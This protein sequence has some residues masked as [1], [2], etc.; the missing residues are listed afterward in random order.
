MTNDSKPDEVDGDGKHTRPFAQFIR[1]V[2][3]G[4]T[5]DEATEKLAE[6]VEAVRETGKAGKMS[7]TLT[8]KPMKGNVDVLLVEDSLV[9]KPPL[10]DRKASIFYP[11]KSGNL[12]RTDPN[13]LT[14]DEPLRAA[15]DPSSEPVRTRKENQA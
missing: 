15:A 7:L 10:H 5:H 6:L 12:T 1:E 14:F 11:D 4:R 8:V 3:N 2:Q 13:Q 9:S